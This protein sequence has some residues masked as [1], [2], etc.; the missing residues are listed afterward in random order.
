MKSSDAAQSEA[1]SVKD[2]LDI[3]ETSSPEIEIAEGI[4]IDSSE[5]NQE[6]PEDILK[7]VHSRGLTLNLNEIKKLN[8]PYTWYGKII[9]LACILLC[10]L[11]IFTFT[12]RVAVAWYFVGGLMMMFLL[13]K[14]LMAM[15]YRPSKAELTKHYKVSTIITCFNEDPSSVLTVFE[16][17]MALDYPVYEVI[18]LDDGSTDTSAYDVARAFAESQKNNPAAPLFS[19]IRFENNRGKRDVLHDGFIRAT[20]DYFFL[21]DSDSEVM[22]NALTELLRP[23]EDEKTTSVVGHINAINKINFLTRLQAISYYSAFQLGRAAQSV[24]GDVAVCSG[25]FSLHKRDFIIKNIKKFMRELYFGI[26]VSS[27]DDRALTY[28]SRLSG[29]KTRYQS[30]A[31]CETMVPTNWKAFQ[32]QRRRWMRSAYLVSADSI[33]NTFP[34][35]PLFIF[36]VFNE[37]YL[38]AVSLIL[39]IIAFFTRG[40]YFN[41]QDVVIYFLIVAY[42]QN[43]FYVV[44][45]PFRWLLSPFYSLAYGCSL[46]LTRFKT[47]FTIKDNGWGTRDTGH[48]EKDYDS[49]LERRLDFVT[50]DTQVTKLL[51]VA[52]PCYKEH[53]TLADVVDNLITSTAY[54]KSMYHIFIGVYSYDSESIDVAYELSNKYPNVHTFVNF[55]VDDASRAKNINFLMQKIKKMEKTNKLSFAAVTIHSAD[56]ILHPYELKATNYL[57]AEHDVLYYPVIPT[58]PIPNAEQYVGD[59]TGEV[60][61]FAPTSGF[62]LSKKVIDSFDGE[63]IF[64]ETNTSFNPLTS[65]ILEEEFRLISLL[66]TRNIPIHYVLEKAP[67]VFQDDSLAYNYMA[68]RSIRSTETKDS[69]LQHYHRRFGGMLLER[70]FMTPNQLETALMV[71]D[72]INMNIGSYCLLQG[73]I[74]EPQLLQTIAY[75]KRVEYFSM[76]DLEELNL[77]EF[78]S[79]FDK[80]FLLE[81]R[82]VPI[83]RFDGGYIMAFSEDSHPKAQTQLRGK[84]SID[85]RTVLASRD[86]IERAIEQM[87]TPPSIDTIMNPYSGE[88]F[89]RYYSGEINYEQAVIANNFKHASRLNDIAVLELM[90]LFISEKPSISDADVNKSF[91]V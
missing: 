82:A 9:I 34:T 89:N 84:Y 3:N 8:R 38:W 58:E 74:T 21:L 56:S 42:F 79:A 91:V 52:I 85:I 80:D 78:A 24:T 65:E 20:G 17:I 37:A 77:H 5:I 44:Y 50:M 43:I 31:Y 26:P 68:I 40:I 64:P 86:N 36:W 18:F 73:F 57:L 46:I 55:G 2:D 69:I 62:V 66:L 27:G 54:P 71:K 6:E 4:D 67:R 48:V 72:R 15:C 14:M 1:S 83:L 49:L 33:I 60:F 87:Y 30:T 75:I 22:P 90:G 76:G 28:I 11:A 16:N 23:F 25:A 29:G 41:L 70:G 61:I 53:E 7:K 51:A 81:L 45:N 63:N 35:K 88:I 13:A 47:I 39:M 10:I 12:A 59:D 19:I 32:K